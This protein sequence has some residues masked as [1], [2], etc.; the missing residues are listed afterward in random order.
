MVLALIMLALLQDPTLDE[1]V[2]RLDHA[3]AEIRTKAA[4]DL[5]SRGTAVVPK[6]VALYRSTSS[7]NVRA[8]TESILIRIPFASLVATRPEEPVHKAIQAHLLKDMESHRTTAGCWLEKERQPTLDPLQV[9]IQ[10][11][12]G[13]GHGQTLRIEDLAPDGKGGLKI[14]RI[15]LQRTTPYRPD[16]KEEGVRVEEAQLNP[17]EAKVLVRLLAAATTMRG[18]CAVQKA[19]RRSWSSS[20]DFTMRVEIQT[21]GRPAW[22]AAYT[23]YPGSLGERVYVHGKILDGVLQA[24]LADRTWS[25]AKLGAQ[26]VEDLLQWISGSFEA[27]KWWVKERYL[28]MAG[29]VGDESYLPFLRKVAD[30]LKEKRGASEER[31]LKAAADALERITSRKDPKKD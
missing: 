6:I 21:P 16:V 26:G 25:D 12:S 3:N 14:R 29:L 17:E 31:Q 2:T 24:A 23:G 15:G 8:G 1:L 5:V 28:A 19:D 30:D 4:D 7:A 9:R 13:S 22:T 27:E 10:R 11:Q 18:T 20:A